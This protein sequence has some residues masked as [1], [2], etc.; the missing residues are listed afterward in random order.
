MKFPKSISGSC[1]LGELYSFLKIWDLEHNWCYPKYTKSQHS[2]LAS[3]L[4]SSNT[5]HYELHDFGYWLHVVEAW[6]DAT[7]LYTVVAILYCCP[8]LCHCHCNLRTATPSYYAASVLIIALPLLIC[9]CATSVVERHNWISC[10]IFDSQV[11]WATSSSLKLQ[12]LQI[13]ADI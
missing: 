1:R 11:K 5:S 8:W 12:R 6:P 7:Q 4:C 13:Y 3:R 9:Y 10:P 2:L